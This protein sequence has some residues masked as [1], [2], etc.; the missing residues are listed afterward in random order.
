MFAMGAR[1]IGRRVSG[2]VPVVGVWLTTI[3]AVSGS[4]A[5][6]ADN[7]RPGADRFPNV[8]LTTHEGTEVRFYDDLIKG[9]T[10]A[11]NLIY[12]TCQYAC[13]L[14]TAKM[15]Q[16]QR[17]LADRMGRDIF[18]YSITIDPEHDTPT[19]LKAFAERYHAGPGWSFLTGKK[20]DIDLISKKLGLYTTPDPQSNPDGHVPYLLIGNEATGQ[21]MRNSAVDN[22]GF[23]ARTIGDWLNSWRNTR[24]DELKSYAEAPRFRLTQGQYLFGT[25]CTPCHTIGAG[26]GIGPDLYGVTAARNHAWLS[27]FI[28]EPEKVIAG[29]DPIAL[30]LLAKY[31]EVRMPSLGLTSPD[32]AAVIEYLTEKSR[33]LFPVAAAARSPA[34]APTPRPAGP[35]SA[36]LTPI[37]DHY[38][39]IQQALHADAIEGIQK[40]AGAIA[41]EAAKLGT[42]GASIR[43][44]AGKLQRVADVKAA[45]AGFGLLSDAIIRYAK[46]RNADVGEDI[47]VAYCPMARKYWLQKGEKVQNPY[48]GKAMSECGRV[49]SDLPDV[50]N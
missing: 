50:T 33:A 27:R 11:I 26:D 35:A 23:I 44:A 40:E 18:F 38:L 7:R 49:V 20:A 14:E 8:A 39:R 3:G 37:V 34:Q 47:E 41:A 31:K 28:L 17:L 13:P 15:A 32:V 42:R 22:P 43:S 9:K 36:R 30:S 5:V 21:W 16:V 10:V 12:T 46:D 24:H 29:G 1:P 25:H 6:A 45:R 4:I 2:L 48:H 19:V